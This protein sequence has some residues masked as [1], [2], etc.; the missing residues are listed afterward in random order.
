MLAELAVADAAA[1]TAL[2]EVAK[3]SLP[4]PAG[5]SGKTPAAA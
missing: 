1:F 4:D 3:K 5:E 2:V